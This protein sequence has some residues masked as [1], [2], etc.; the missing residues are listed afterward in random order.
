MFIGFGVIAVALIL[1]LSFC[2]GGSDDPTPA[3]TN[4]TAQAPAEVKTASASEIELA[5]KEARKA[6]KIRPL[7]NGVELPPITGSCSSTM[8]ASSQVQFAEADWPAAWQGD[9]QAQRNVAFCLISGCDGAV[10]ID[11]SSGCAWRSVILALNSQSAT[12]LDAANIETE[13]GDLT[14][15]QRQL[16]ISKA[17][18]IAAKVEALSR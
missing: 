14:P 13:C 6:F 11:K 1:V 8:C 12:D 2:S 7:P 10:Q 5:Q 3:P 15:T 18:K 4:R 9:Y 16:A 17:Q